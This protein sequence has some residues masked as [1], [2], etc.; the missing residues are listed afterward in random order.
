NAAG[1][2]TYRSA[3]LTSS[4]GPNRR[5]RPCTATDDQGV[6]FPRPLLFVRR[7][8]SLLHDRW[9]TGDLVASRALF[10]A[11]R[12]KALVITQVHAVRVVALMLGHKQLSFPAVR[13]RDG[14]ERSANRTL[15]CLHVVSVRAGDAILLLDPF[16]RDRIG[17]LLAADEDA[18][19]AR[20]ERHNERSTERVFRQAH[21]P[22]KACLFAGLLAL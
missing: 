4:D 11:D 13:Q 10:D 8:R 21:V 15:R 2:C 18:R 19:A 1:C 20:D 14:H 17:L 12:V 9:R 7:L 6:L 5:A 22:H 3:L 16:W